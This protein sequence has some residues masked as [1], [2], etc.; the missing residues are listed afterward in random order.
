MNTKSTRDHIIDAADQLFY[1]Q[2]Y[3]HT[4]FADISGAVKISRG[5]FYHHFKTK[6]EIL[7]AVINRRITNTRT[8]LNSWEDETHS[9]AQRICCFVNILITNQTKIMQYGCPVGTLATELTKLH[10]SAQPEAVKLFTLFRE[11]LSGQFTQLGHADRADA[12]AMH[13]LARSQGI[14]SLASAFQ[15]AAFVKQEVDDACAWVLSL[16]QEVDQKCS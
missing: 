15:D 16:S 11:W 10:H 1:Q 6:D 4:S 12:L 7:G 2:G 14:A 5:N 8:L 3:N 13:L 9:P